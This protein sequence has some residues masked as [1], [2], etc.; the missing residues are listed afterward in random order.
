MHQ[1]LARVVL[2]HGCFDLLPLGHIRHLREAKALGDR[3]VVSVTADSYVSKGVGRPRFTA[4][5]RLESIL[6]LECVDEG[7]ISFSPNAVSAIE[8]VKPSIFVKGIDYANGG[9][10]A[11][12][13]EIAAVEKHGGKFITTK[14]EKWSSS[15]LINGETLPEA[16]TSYLDAARS[17]GFLAKIVDAFEKADKLTIAFV[18]ETIIDEYRYVQALG[19][20]SKEPCLATV[21]IHSEW[22]KGGVAA[23]GLHGEWPKTKTITSE[24]KIYKTR[25]VDTAFFRKLFE[26]Y[27]VQRLSFT[28]QGRKEIYLSLD[29]AI[30]TSDVVVV[31]DFG[32]G[33]IDKLARDMLENAKFLAINAQSNAGNYGFNPVTKYKHAD[34][35][36]VDDPEARLALKDQFGKAEVMITQIAQFPGERAIIT[37]GSQPT[38]T[39][40]GTKVSRVP[41]FSSHGI[42]TM[43]AGDAFL[44]VTAPLVAV[45]LELEA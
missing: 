22:F 36:C 42:D 34:L 25:Y 28:P 8:T 10:L 14:S 30:K 37:H 5:Q 13:Q 43:G 3:L 39:Y 44:A 11:L 7:F 27:S 45:G 9:D 35:I 26:V 29:E 24:Q 33:L 17:R 15:R 31:F 40:D 1:P 20:P 21:E 18:G 23:A 12:K 32:H 4:E 6:A 2:A 19:K 41:V 16:V 38:L